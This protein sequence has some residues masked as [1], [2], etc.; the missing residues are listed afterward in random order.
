MELQLS[1][2]P[3]QIEREKAELSV[4]VISLSERLEEAEGGAENQVITHFGHQQCH[5]APHRLIV[6]FLSSLLSS[7]STASVTSS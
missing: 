4:T 6:R 2:S 1:S 7:K 5:L 3:L